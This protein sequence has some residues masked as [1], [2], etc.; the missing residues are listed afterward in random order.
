[1]T[2]IIPNMTIPKEWRAAV[3]AWKN[4]PLPEMG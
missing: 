4:T 1:M 3:D 2:K